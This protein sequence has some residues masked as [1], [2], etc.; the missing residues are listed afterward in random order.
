LRL[1]KLEDELEPKPLKLEIFP[2]IFQNFL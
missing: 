1:L 2:T